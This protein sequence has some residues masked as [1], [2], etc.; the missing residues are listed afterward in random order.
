M[1]TWFRLCLVIILSLVLF[2][3]AVLSTWP[4]E[5]IPVACNRFTHCEPNISIQQ[6]T[7]GFYH[8][9]L[10][11]D[12]A[13]LD[14]L[15][16][17]LNVQCGIIAISAAI[18]ETPIIFVKI[19]S[20]SE[21]LRLHAEALLYRRLTLPWLSLRIEHIST[22]METEEYTLNSVN[23]YCRN[24]NNTKHFVW[25]IHD[26]GAFHGTPENER[27]MPV[28]TGFALGA[29]CQDQVKNKGSD[30]CGMRWVRYPHSHFAA[31]NMWI[32]RCSYIARLPN[33]SEANRRRCSGERGL[34]YPNGTLALNT[35]PW[36][37]G[38]GRFASEHW[39][40]LGSATIQTSDCLGYL[41][42]ADGTVRTYHH[43][44]VNLEF[45]SYGMNCTIAPKPELERA[46]QTGHIPHHPGFYTSEYYP[47]YL[48]SKEINL[49]VDKAHF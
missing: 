17:L 21:P 2:A 5:N 28:A 12:I 26:K 48:L 20:E 27:L 46:F 49:L 33:V 30:L 47:L 23:S 44:Y 38:C 25:Y 15:R 3:I 24:P 9:W 13:Q 31:S 29:G 22:V 45:E 16:A 8:L 37:I 10:P 40:G 42:D 34:I 18:A 14:R 6:P 1:C 36:V 41:T 11:N 35:D 4:A 19:I 32:A 39:I 7:V 43:D